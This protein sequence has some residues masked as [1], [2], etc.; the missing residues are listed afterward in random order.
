MQV[1]D[2][3][4]TGMHWQVHK[5]SARHGK[6]YYERG[7]RMPV[8]VTIGGAIC[9]L[10]GTA[11]AFELHQFQAGMTGGR[12][13]IALAAVIV[14]GWRPWPAL[15]A[16]LAFATLDALQI[17]LQNQ[18]RV[19]AQIFAVLPFVATLVALAVVS[20]RKSGSARPPPGLGK[21]PA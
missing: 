19:P 7:E 9:G 6:R 4:T 2:S 15:G 12:G 8:A 1:Y 20:Q 14:A 5:V 3:Q 18:T 10:G 21:H 16:C 11:L 13:F 17:V